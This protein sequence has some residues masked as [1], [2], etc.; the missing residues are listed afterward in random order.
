MRINR[1]VLQLR[2]SGYLR[3]PPLRLYRIEDLAEIRV[4]ERRFELEFGEFQVVM[5]T[6]NYYEYF[7]RRYASF[8]EMVLPQNGL[9]VIEV[10]FKARKRV[11][12]V[13]E[14][15]GKVKEVWDTLGLPGVT[16]LVKI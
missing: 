16:L 9:E 6:L 13:K 3:L 7:N 14:L 4:A 1:A 12:L 8:K 10:V 15:R 11:L 2:F 5:D